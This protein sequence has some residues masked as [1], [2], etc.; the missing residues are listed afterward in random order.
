MILLASR[1][2]ARFTAGLHDAIIVAWVRKRG[3]GS[4]G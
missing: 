3:E 2:E 1:V 4:I